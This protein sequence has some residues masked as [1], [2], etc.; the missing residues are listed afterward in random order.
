MRR[1]GFGFSLILAAGSGCGDDGTG[2]GGGDGGT[3]TGGAMTTSPGSDSTGGSPGDS[4]S[5]AVDSTGVGGSGSSGG[6]SGSSG[7][8]SGSSG[9]TTTGDSGSGS[10]GGGNAMIE[11]TVSGVMLFQDCM[12]IVDPDPLGITGTIDIM[13]TGDEPA[14]ATVVDGRII[15]G[16]GAEVGTFTTVEAAFGPVPVGESSSETFTKAD[17]SLDPAN[18]CGVAMCNQMYTVELVLDVDGVE[19]IAGAMGSVSCVF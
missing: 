1:L 7:G 15:D 14:T 18:G 9:G 2:D 3:S 4:S 10:S 16:G 5:G 13:N 17:N 8:D 19:V 11:A 6:D 12:P